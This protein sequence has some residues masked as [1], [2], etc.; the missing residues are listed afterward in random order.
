M[1]SSLAS[2]QSGRDHYADL[3][4][5][6]GEREAEWLRRTAPQKAEAVRAL[7]APEALAPTSVLEIG[8]GT[9]AV[10][11][12][13]RRLGIGRE[14]YAVDFS[15]E[16]VAVLERHHPGIRAA[17]A[18]ITTTPDP[19][20]TGAY[21]L[22]LASHVIEHLEE[23][24]RFL[25]ALLSVPLAHFIAEVPL[26]NLLGGRVKARLKEPGEQRRR[27]RPVFRQTLVREP[28]RTQ[29]LAG[30]AC[31]DVRAV[32]RCRDARVRVPGCGPENS[33]DQIS[34]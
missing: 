18:D 34:D 24:E 4:R 2:G 28:A 12:A 5:T 10:I 17:V 9:G 33:R 31:R 16:A 26:E 7:L 30:P 20:G 14:H 15:P 3:Y 32:A 22:G 6:D 13:L 11:G 23:P 21:D 27:A 1:S 8:A 25:R 29:R 19:F